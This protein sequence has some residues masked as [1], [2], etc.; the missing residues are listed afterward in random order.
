[1]RL[2]L[3]LDHQC[4]LRCTYCYNG[5]KFAAPMS[6]ATARAAIDLVLDRHAPLAQV[7]FFGGEPLLRLPLVKELVA[8][9][10][11]RTRGAEKPPQLVMTTNATRLDEPTVRWLKEH[12][13]FLGISIDG[14]PEAHD[15][16]RRT[17]DG[18]G[19]H[20]A[21][22][23]GL[24]QALD[25]GVPLKTL[26]VVDA[27]NVRW[28][29][30]SFDY[31]LDAGVRSIA[32][33]PNYEGAWDEAARDAYV[34]ALDRLVDRYVAAWRRGLSFRFT[35]LDSKIVTHLKGGFSCADRC[36]FGGEELAVSPS[37]RLYPCDRLVG[38]DDRE[39]VVI[40][41]VTEGV[42]AARRDA[43][44]RAKNAVLEECRDCEWMPRCMHWCGCVNYAMTGDVGD[45]SGLLCWFE[46]TTIAAADRAAQALFADANPGF[47]KR[48]YRSVLG[49]AAAE[50]SAPEA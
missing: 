19:S 4:D 2:T 6:L 30:E 33:N 28:M 26:T 13:F 18:R 8:Y 12:D 43:L 50:P 48:F 1:M 45:V 10:G 39:D 17:A 22:V 44:V 35:L 3:F 29:A 41:T 46:K 40:G 7:G 27:A 14:C 42:D 38:E 21:V 15:A 20:E 24:R 31:L 36:D 32:F 23:A 49:R 34:A 11:E 5:E 25:G 37:G 9:V 47:L 16:C